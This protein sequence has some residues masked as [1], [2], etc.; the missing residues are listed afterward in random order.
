MKVTSR[1][2][3]IVL[4]IVLIVALFAAIQV[5]AAPAAQT[6]IPAASD[7]LE[8]CSICHKNSG[9]TH[10]EYYDKLYQDGVVQVS[11]IKY[12]FKPNPDTTTVTFKL[13]QNGQPLDPKQADNLS[14][15]WVPY[16]DG[17]F[18][19]EPAMD[20]LSVKGK[21]TSDGKGTVTSTLVELPKDD[22]AYVDYT[23]V[24]K[25][26]GL[27][28]I[29]GRDGTVGTIPNSRVAQ[30]MYPFAGLLQTGS[31]VDYAST[32]STATSTARSTA[33]PR[34]IS[35]PARPAISTTAR[36]AITSGSCWST[37]RCS[38]PSSSR[39]P[40]RKPPS[41]CPTRRR[42]TWRTTRPS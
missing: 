18:Q 24:S 39:P 23:D 37:T 26:P 16:K 40:K 19:F 9:S 3:W 11:D 17:K 35:T 10:Q 20:R 41:C 13:T 36:E 28:V 42:R 4:A 8:T 21:I 32:S 30:T 22:K 31:G 12:A 2:L 14:M 6:A 7:T 5:T 1:K 27:L 25:T 15:Y 38:R 33:T 34:P 29:Y